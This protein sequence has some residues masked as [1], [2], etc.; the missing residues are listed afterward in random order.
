MSWNAPDTKFWNGVLTRYLLCYNQP[1]RTP[2]CRFIRSSGRLQGT[3]YNLQPTTKYFVT[4]S[5]GTKVGYG[6]KSL[7]ISKIT[8]GG[9]TLVRIEIDEIEIDLHFLFTLCFE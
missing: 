8:S 9:K 4:V 7:E 6:N 3:I 2:R 5:A 1:A